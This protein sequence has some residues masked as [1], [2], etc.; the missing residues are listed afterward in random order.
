MSMNATSITVMTL[1]AGGPPK[2][3]AGGWIAVTI[4]KGVLLLT[5]QELTTA[6]RRGKRLRRRQQFQARLQA[7]EGRC[8]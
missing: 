4:G 2:G 1:L 8:D 5:S 7:E 3:V 6:L